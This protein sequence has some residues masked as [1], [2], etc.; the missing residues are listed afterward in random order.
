MD[1]LT[2]F[3]KPSKVEISADSVA[4]RRVPYHRRPLEIQHSGLPYPLDQVGLILGTILCWT[5]YKCSSNTTLI[6]VKFTYD[7][8]LTL[9]ELLLVWTLLLLYRTSLVSKF[10]NVLGWPHV[11]LGHSWQKSVKW[12]ICGYERHECRLQSALQKLNNTQ[13][14]VTDSSLSRHTVLKASLASC[15]GLVVRQLT[16]R[17]FGS[18]G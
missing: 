12:I 7:C 17:F 8:E 4:T 15:L 1:S 10:V 6:V 13:F 3:N 9:G 14:W 18:W 5:I 2:S 11:E 16:Q